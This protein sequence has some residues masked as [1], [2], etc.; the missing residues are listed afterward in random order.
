[1][2]P[3]F[4]ELF[5]LFNDHNVEYL[6]VGGYA[7]AF[8]GAPRYTGDIDLYV[9]PTEENARKITASLN[10][11]GFGDVGLNESDFC[12]ADQVIQLGYAPIRIDLITSI[13][14]VSWDQA[15]AT[16]VGGSYDDIPI[17]FIGIDELI[18]NKRATG[19][20]KDLADLE[21]LGGE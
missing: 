3:D 13:D 1:M 2:F 5:E 14:G 9:R 21:A 19:R 8:H 7:V 10:E 18:A 6:V 17:Q 11:F 4:K 12:V 16:A 15:N 20:Q